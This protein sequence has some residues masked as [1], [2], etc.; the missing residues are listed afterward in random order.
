MY[1]PRF[2][3]PQ[4]HIQDH[5]YGNPEH[6]SLLVTLV[7]PLRRASGMTYSTA[8]CMYNKNMELK[9]QKGRKAN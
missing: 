6:N 9:D 1:L 8:T 7:S 4:R 5:H 2:F 3:L